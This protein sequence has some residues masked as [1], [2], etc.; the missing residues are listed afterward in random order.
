MT[1]TFGTSKPR[2]PTYNKGMRDIIAGDTTVSTVGDGPLGL[3]FRGYEVVELAR[4]CVFE[5]VLY[6]F[7]HS[8]LPN[9]AELDQFCKE[10]WTMRR[11][12]PSLK[13]VL[14]QIGKTANFF[15]VAREV[16]SFLGVIDAEKPDFSD[17]KQKAMRT[18]AIIGPAVMYWYHF[19]NKGIR[20]NEV[21]GPNDS[22][23]CNLVKL[24]NLTSDPDPFIV[25][26]MDHML[27]LL[28]DHDFSASAFTCRVAA[29]SRT[30]Y[31]SAISAALSAMKGPIHGGAYF[32]V[33]SYLKK[34]NTIEEADIFLDRT[35]NDKTVLFGF[36]HTINKKMTDPRT[37]FMLQM[38][39][40]LAKTS[41]GSMKAFNI[42]EHIRNRALKEKGLHPN[43]DFAF[44]VWSQQCGDRIV[45][46]LPWITF[47]IGRLG[48][49]SAHIFD[50]RTN[51]TIIRPSSFYIGH[52][53]RQINRQKL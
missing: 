41:N 10:M 53:P 8:D 47:L 28:G 15:G 23:A 24:M 36:G 1:D 32:E 50:Q 17:Q 45:P 46:E 3:R 16:S 37:K 51:K 21:T 4:H 2:H 5:E 13:I 40:D 43:V 7:L 33:S 18:V 22:V 49:L 29:S 39:E 35:F 48:G 30:D 14:E 42:A 12:P 6:L 44:E 20:I 27:C 19:A 34:L 11:L 31:D 52:G 38:A 9:K 26:S 25:K